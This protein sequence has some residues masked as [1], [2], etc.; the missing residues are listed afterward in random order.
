MLEA[1]RSDGSRRPMINLSLSGHDWA[2]H[3]NVARSFNYPSGC[4]TGALN[5]FIPL[6]PARVHTHRNSVNR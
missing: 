4:A 2:T 6:E 1:E 5:A 3:I